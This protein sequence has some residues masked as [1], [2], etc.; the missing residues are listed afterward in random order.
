MNNPIQ[1]KYFFNNT[2]KIYSLIEKKNEYVDSKQNLK[3]KFLEI[4]MKKNVQENLFYPAKKSSVLPTKITTHFNLKKSHSSKS[5]LP[6]I[7]EIDLDNKNVNYYKMLK[8]KDVMIAT[9]KIILDDNPI[10]VGGKFPVDVYSVRVIISDNNRNIIFQK[11]LGPSKAGQH[12]FKINA[13]EIKKKYLSLDKNHLKTYNLN[14]LAK[15]NTEI[16]P[17]IALIKGHVQDVFISTANDIFINVYGLGMIP[18]LD[19]YSVLEK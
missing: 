10:I 6:K 5:S 13:H 7:H 1:F 14:I 4:L 17:S 3:N 19:V 18:L 2:N 11:D 15:T 8:G 9:S 12:I 16:F